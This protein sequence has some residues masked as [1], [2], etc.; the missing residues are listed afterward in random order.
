MFH[1]SAC[2]HPRARTIAPVPDRPFSGEVFVRREG[3]AVEDADPPSITE[4]LRELFRVQQQRADIYSRM[5]Q[6]VPLSARRRGP[7]PRSGLPWLVWRDRG[8]RANRTHPSAGMRASHLSRCLEQL[9][10]PDDASGGAA[11][12]SFDELIGSGDEPAYQIA[13]QAITLEFNECSKQV[14][15]PGRSPR[16]LRR[17]PP[18]GLCPHSVHTRPRDGVSM[19]GDVPVTGSADRRGVPA[20]GG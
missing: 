2:P 15:H 7:R 18:R 20:A 16:R 19:R 5:K 13:M 8:S 11:G 17:R 3:T 1:H 10:E 9:S 6:C 14:R 12:R 4:L